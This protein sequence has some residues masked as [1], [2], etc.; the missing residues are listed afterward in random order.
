MEIQKK[1]ALAAAC[2]VFVLL[3]APVAL[4]FPRG[5]VGL[6]ITVSLG[7]FALYYVGLI[8]G[9][10]L[11][12]KLILPAFWAIWLP[13]LIFT[14]VGIVL[15]MRVRKGGANARVSGGELAE[16]IYAARLR[17]ARRLGREGR[18]RQVPVGPNKGEGA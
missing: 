11:A 3:G 7:A 9:E 15:L 12:D 10:T 1:F 16:A 13:N 14:A 8:A 18:S 5:G 17:I 2:A 4:R 6:V